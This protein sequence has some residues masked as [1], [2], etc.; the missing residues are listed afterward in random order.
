[1]ILCV[2]PIFPLSAHLSV[3]TMLLPRLD[4]CEKCCRIWGEMAGRGTHWNSFGS[5]LITGISISSGSPIFSF[6]RNYYPVFH[7]GYTNF[8]SCQQCRR[9]SFLPH[10][11]QH[12]LFSVSGCGHP[13]RREVVAHCSFDLHFPNDE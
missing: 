9:I 4:H 11:P 1:M 8:P 10:P 5:I 12:L 3:D 7:S 2:Q 6:L 13:T